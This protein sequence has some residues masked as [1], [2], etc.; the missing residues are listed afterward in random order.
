M[1]K[2]LSSSFYALSQFLTFG[3]WWEGVAWGLPA[4]VFPL[5]RWANS[6]HSHFAVFLTGTNWHLMLSL[7]LSSGVKH[8][9]ILWPHCEMRD[10]DN[11]P[12]PFLCSSH[13]HSFLMLGPHVSCW[14]SHEL[15]LPNQLVFCANP[16]MPGT[17]FHAPIYSRKL[18]WFQEACWDH[19]KCLIN[20]CI[21][22]KGLRDEVPSSSK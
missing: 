6:S 3:W 21:M 20:M 14:Y 13:C 5:L 19:S 15:W 18:A 1:R 11:Q 7:W 9:F 22:K 4:P 12:F 2:K 16:C 8:V 10:P 17:V